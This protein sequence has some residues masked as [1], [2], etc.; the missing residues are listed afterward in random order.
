MTTA[1]A[2]ALAAGPALAQSASGG[3][4][5]TAPNASAI[6]GGYGNTRTITE[7][8]TVKS[9]D[10]ATRHITVTNKKGDSFT[11]KASPAVRN[12]AK[13]KAG[14]K[15]TATYYVEYLFL[16]ANGATKL[17]DDQVATA[18]ARAPKGSMPAAAIANRTVV[19]GAVLGIDMAKHTLKVVDPNGGQVHTIKVTNPARQKQMNQL[20][21]GDTITA[22]VTEALL[23]SVSAPS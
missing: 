13:I 6:T 7:T 16:V 2:V 1:V 11:L 9:V 14:D 18:V 3:A 19:T 12:F 22:S 10:A 21:V 5:S 4:S 15:L 20:K 23:V 8:L 17:P